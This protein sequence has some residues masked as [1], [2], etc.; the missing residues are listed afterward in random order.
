MNEHASTILSLVRALTIAEKT[1][2][3]HSD[4]ADRLRMPAPA[5]RVLK[6]AVG[7]G[8]LSDPGWASGLADMQAASSAFLQ[9]LGGRSAFASLL[10]L[11]VLTRAPLRSRVGAVTEGVVTDVTGEG[12][13]RPVSRMTLSGD[14]LLPQQADA[15]VVL[16]REV[17]ENSSAASQAFVSR[18]LR[19]AVAR[20]LDVGFFDRLVTSSTPS[21]TS[22]GD[23]L[24]DLKTM[25]DAV[26]TGQGRLCW[27]ASTSAANSIALLNDGRGSASPEGVSEFLNLPFAVSPGLAAGTLILLDGDRVLADIESLGVDI[28]RFATLQMNDEPTMDA[29]TPTATAV[30]SLWQTNAI[31]VK[32]SALFG[33]VAGTP[34]ALAVL[35][36]IEWPPVV[37]G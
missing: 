1:G 30:V 3:T 12:Q 8:T 26:N 14:A 11:G 28:S 24:S 23:H 16:S 20:A 18:Q 35:T 17:I 34:D 36:G 31:A 15:I 32:V 25:L 22:S 10:D 19:R 9:G 6:A 7:A 37:S 21:F 27:V 5:A 13:S 29:I 2:E 33:A 4:I